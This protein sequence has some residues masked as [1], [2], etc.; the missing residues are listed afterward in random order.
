MANTEILTLFEQQP[1]TAACTA[2]QREQFA[3]ILEQL[4]EANKT[5]NLTAVADAAT[6]VTIHFADS[7][8]LLDALRVNGHGAQFS[9]AADIGAGAGFPT[10]PCAVVMPQCQWYAVESTGKK[11]RFTQACAAAAGLTN[12]H[13]LNMRAEDLGHTEATAEVLCARETCDIVTARA[14]ASIPTLMEVGLPLVKVG[15]L[16]ML[17]KTDHTDPA[18]LKLASTLAH[19]FGGSREP[20]YLYSFA[21]DTYRRMIL[22]IRK[23]RSC[24]GNYPRANGIP[25]KKPLASSNKKSIK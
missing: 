15:G 19:E 22:C 25:F 9:V 6:A 5:I 18:E 24:P 4:L 11:S 3:I 14:V 17:F 12:V 10:L 23:I 7:L 8:A 16:L 13:A 1:I 21:G 20:D 2:Q